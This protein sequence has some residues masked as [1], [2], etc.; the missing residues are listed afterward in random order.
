[1]SDIGIFKRGD[2]VRA[3]QKNSENCSAAYLIEAGKTYEVIKALNGDPRD[4]WS[5]YVTLKRC[6]GEKCGGACVWFSYRFTRADDCQPITQEEIDSARL[7]PS[8]DEVRK[9]LLL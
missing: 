8:A 1:M 7:L 3:I 9:E 4:K 5:S 2:F 6:S